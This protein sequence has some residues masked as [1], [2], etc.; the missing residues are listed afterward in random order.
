MKKLKIYCDFDGT[1]TTTDNIISLMKQFAPPE[2][3]SIKDDILAQKTSIKEGVGEMFRLLPSSSR[4][5]LIDYLLDTHQ[6]RTGFIDFIE[7]SNQNNID[8]K[9]VSGGIDFFVEPILEGIVPNEKIFC[10]SSDFS[11]DTIRITWPYSCD[12]HCS[13]ECGCCKT[14]II[15]NDSEKGD[16]IIVIGDSITDLEGAKMADLVLACDDFLAGKCEELGLNYL[17]FE[18]FDE[19]ISILKE[20]NREAGTYGKLPC[21]VE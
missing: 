8:L 14:S 12:E 7:W 18:T 1:I 20:I 11:G 10:N 2:W 3:I 13:N 19:V 17:S 5:K 21:E 16:Y 9:I 6:L 4:A 15:R